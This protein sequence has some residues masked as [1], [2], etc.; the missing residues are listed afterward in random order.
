[1]TDQPWAEGS[2]STWEDLEGD[3]RIQPGAEVLVGKHRAVEPLSGGETARFSWNR[4]GGMDAHVGKRLT[5]D[6]LSC[7]LI[8][9]GTRV[10][11]LVNGGP[12]SWRARDL[13][14]LRTADGKLT[15]EGKFLDRVQAA[16]MNGRRYWS[17][18]YPLHNWASRAGIFVELL[19]AR[20]E[21]PYDRYTVDPRRLDMALGREPE[22]KAPEQEALSCSACP[23]SGSP[24]SQ[25]PCCTCG[26]EGHADLEKPTY[27]FDGGDQYVSARVLGA[28]NGNDVFETARVRSI[29][30]P[31][32]TAREPSPVETKLQV[33]LDGVDWFDVDPQTPLKPGRYLLRKSRRF[34]LGAASAELI[35]RELSP[36]EVRERA[37]KA[38][39]PPKECPGC[40]RPIDSSRDRVDLYSMCSDCRQIADDA[41]TAHDVRPVVEDRSG[42][43]HLD[44]LRRFITGPHREWR[45]RR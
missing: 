45:H 30:T 6:A 37:A 2:G 8:A 17:E 42:E 11:D 33:S 27:H 13:V 43:D 1:M 22:A 41:A 15:A 28:Y 3:P 25:E 29:M 35:D 4:F 7:R 40:H 24:P 10:V 12:W 26:G 38:L 32:I 5:V 39:K 18:N 34:A 36:R 23:H 14:C 44:G 9:N 16:F 20:G 21:T 19:Y 31:K